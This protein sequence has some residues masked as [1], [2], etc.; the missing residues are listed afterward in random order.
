[1]AGSGWKSPKLDNFFLFEQTK[2]EKKKKNK[3]ADAA[4][5]AA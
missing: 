4:G 5:G 3:K 2:V 1:M